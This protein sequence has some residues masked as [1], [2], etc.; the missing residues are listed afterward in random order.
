MNCYTDIEKARQEHRLHG[1]WLL[2]V[3]QTSS[4][5]PAV[6]MACWDEGTVKDMRG[7]KYIDACLEHQCWDETSSTFQLFLKHGL[8]LNGTRI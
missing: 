1:G 8:T 4:L 3:A 7:Q 6:Y 5:G 2:Q